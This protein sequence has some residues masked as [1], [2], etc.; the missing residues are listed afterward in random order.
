MVT[1][2]FQFESLFIEEKSACMLQHKN[3][4][5]SSVLRDNA[6]RSLPNKLTKYRNIDISNTNKIDHTHYVFDQVDI[7]TKNV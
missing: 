3:K 6:K 7:K 5:R 4:S 1:M 2:V